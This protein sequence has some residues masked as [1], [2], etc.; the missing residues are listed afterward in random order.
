MAA[1]MESEE[2]TVPDPELYPVSTFEMTSAFDAAPAVADQ[3]AAEVP[4]A[5][6][7]VT[8]AAVLPDKT[9]TLLDPEDCTVT[10]PVELLTMFQDCPR[11]NVEATGNVTVCVDE[12]VK[13]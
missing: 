8:T 12:P 10:A 7:Q 9:I 5:K 1:K 3:D 11:T 6:I 13:Y 2:E 4:E